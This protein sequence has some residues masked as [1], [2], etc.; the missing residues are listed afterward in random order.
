MTDVF[1]FQQTWHI[2]PRLSGIKH[3]AVTDICVQK[4]KKPCISTTLKTK[5][6]SSEGIKSTVYNPLQVPL[7]SISLPCKLSPF[8]NSVCPT[9]RPQF[10]QLWNANDS[11]EMVKFKY[12][13]VPKG[14]ILSY[15]LPVCSVE[16]GQI[17]TVNCDELPPDFVFPD[18]STYVKCH[19]PIDIAYINLYKSLFVSD[20]M[21]REF[22]EVT[23]GQSST[24]EWHRLRK[25]R[26][27]ASIFKRVCSRK[28]NFESLA[29]DLMS[30]R[31]VT[32]A[33]MKH[34][35]ENEPVAAE[36]YAH[37]FGRNVFPIGFVVNPSC[38]FL[39]A[40]PDRRVYDPDAAVD[41]WG[42]LEIK[43][44]TANSVSS[45]DYLI[46][47]KTSGKTQMQL[48]RNHDYYYQVIGQMGISGA[49]WC[50]FF[51]YAKDDFYV[52]RITFDEIFF[53]EMMFKLCNFFFNFFMPQMSC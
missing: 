50:D 12:G 25:N 43:C 36:V 41:K 52:E 5:R 44:T 28:T 53:S 45:C 46:P 22:E 17:V 11:L 35:I 9:E 27:T 23:R 2:P 34:G 31:H 7:N 16:S 8:F 15:Q 13:N 14:S 19:F 49:S 1:C 24:E 26:L 33:A 37:S 42:L 39:G 20:V 18:L 38:F 21:S 4:P 51:V 29:T 48:K 30:T 6:V 40:S 32:T 47:P 10:A 3:R